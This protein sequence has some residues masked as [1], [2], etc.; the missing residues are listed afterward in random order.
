MK[1]YL[2]ILALIPTFVFAASF[3]CS[4]ASSI[5]EKTICNNPTIS[6]L[7]NK[8]AEAYKNAKSK[9]S[10]ESKLKS[11]QLAWIKESRTC[12]GDSNC[13]EKS[14]KDRIAALGGTSVAT[15]NLPAQEIKTAPTASAAATTQTQQPK[16]QPTHADLIARAANSIGPD[17]WGKCSAAN[18][19]MTVWG[20]QDKSVP[21]EIIE[22]NKEFGTM[23]GEIRK[24]YLAKGIPDATL[25]QYL[26]IWNGKISAGDQAMGIS[27][28]C[29]NTISKAL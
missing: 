16:N 8:L 14:Y 15:K 18:V 6:E 28:N 29:M 20:M 13:L 9:T 23:L 25:G 17:G 26:K 5:T 10:D 7:D 24:Y 21:K 3:D 1:I 2:S 19:V 12:G 22:T 27:S 11:E 4:K